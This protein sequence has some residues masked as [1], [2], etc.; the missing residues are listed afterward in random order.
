MCQS[1]LQQHDN[2]GIQLVTILGVQRFRTFESFCNT[3]SKKNTFL[4]TCPHQ[5]GFVPKRSKQSPFFSSHMGDF[6]F[7]LCFIYLYL[8]HMRPQ[9]RLVSENW[10][11]LQWSPL[12]SRCRLTVFMFLSFFSRALVWRPVHERPL[13]QPWEPRCRPLLPGPASARPVSSRGRTSLSLQLCLSQA[14]AHSPR[15]LY[16]PSLK[17]Q[18]QHLPAGGPSAGCSPSLGLSFLTCKIEQVLVSNS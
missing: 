14:L 3:T 9:S 5:Q 18:L 8:I 17:S 15:R 13:C 11:S 10:G 4:C 1:K 2:Q 16:K 7:K 6:F 12:A